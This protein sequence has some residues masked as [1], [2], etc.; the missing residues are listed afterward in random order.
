M[1]FDFT[2]STAPAVETLS[3]Y[4]QQNKT[5]NTKKHDNMTHNHSHSK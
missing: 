2:R 1:L 3:D 4:K 5:H